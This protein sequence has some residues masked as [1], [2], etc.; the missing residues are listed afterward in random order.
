MASGISYILWALIWL[1]ACHCQ[2]VTNTFCADKECQKWHTPYENMV[3]GL[4]GYDPVLGDPFDDNG[5]PGLKKQIFLPTY[6][7]ERL[8]GGGSL[9]LQPFIHAQDDV[10]CSATLTT[11]K[12]SSFAE[13]ESYRTG[14][15]SSEDWSKN[16][17]N[18]DVWLPGLFFNAKSSSSGFRSKKNNTETQKLWKFFS[19]TNG[20]IYITEATCQM[21]TMEI[22]AFS[23]LEFNPG[24]INAL[25]SLQHASRDPNSR[26]SNRIFKTFVKNFGTFYVDK[27]AMGAKFWI[28]TRFASQSSSQSTSQARMECIHDSFKN[29]HSSG[30]EAPPIKSVEAK[31]VKIET[32]WQAVNIGSDSGNQSTTNRCSGNSGNDN[33]FDNNSIRSTVVH[34]IGSKSFNDLE[35]WINNEFFP[36]PIEYQI[37]PMN[38]ILKPFWEAFTPGGNLGDIPMNANEPSGEKLDSTKINDFFLEKVQQY[39]KIIL[40]E[41]DCPFYDVTGCGI[42][43]YCEQNE[44]CRNVPTTISK[45]GLV[46]LDRDSQKEERL[47]NAFYGMNYAIDNYDRRRHIATFKELV[48]TT[49]LDAPD[50][51]KGP[52]RPGNTRDGGGDTLLIQAAFWK[53]PKEIVQLLLDNGANINYQKK[54]YG[55]TAL[56]IAAMRGHK[57]VVQLLLDRGANRRLKTKRIRGKS[58][59][60]DTACKY[61]DKVDYIIPSCN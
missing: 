21:Y 34:S 42:A 25:R 44:F 57:D 17:S 33:Y 39:C 7:A 35:N 11:K 32:D 9:D 19:E 20:E 31:G 12:I 47:W 3:A 43:G 6:E 36:V 55:Q 40:G 26:L 41:D 30:F 58:R 18:A 45:D 27:V 37:A 38:K 51:K 22:D 8:G 5:D 52:N 23:K 14:S 61:N 29:G 10:R 53:F 60:G 13:Y 16:N 46:C 48:K 59:G 2:K 50:T 1:Q 49:F 28:E 24:F 4:V 56:M 15:F 54:K